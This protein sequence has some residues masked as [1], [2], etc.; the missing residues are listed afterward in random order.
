MTKSEFSLFVENVLENS[1]GVLRA[2]N[3]NYSSDV[4]PLHNFNA[5]AD[6][7]GCTPPQAAWFYCVK[8][9]TALRDKIL[10]NDFSDVADFQEKITD[11]IDYLIFIYALGKEE[12]KKKKNAKNDAIDITGTRLNS[13]A[14]T[15]FIVNESYG[16]QE[17]SEVPP[18]HSAVPPM[19]PGEK[20]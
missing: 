12:N 11:S 15:R 5:G 2:K 16:K 10:R 18:V 20:I 6:I 4:D 7:G 14:I 13:E 17:N 19:S 8:H 1:A 3:A 9:L